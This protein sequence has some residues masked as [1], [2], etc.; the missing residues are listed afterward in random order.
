M[1][2]AHRRLGFIAVL[3]WAWVGPAWAAHLNVLPAPQ[4][5][6]P[7]GRAVEVLIPRAEI[8]AQIDELQLENSATLGGAIS[9]LIDAK[10]NHDRASRAE[11]AIRPLRDALSGFDVEALA[12]ST[13]KAALAQTPWFHATSIAFGRDTTPAGLNAALDAAATDQAAFVTYAYTLSTNGLALS[14]TMTLQL[15]NKA[16]PKGGGPDA[17]FSPGRLAYSQTVTA[18]V[19]LPAPAPSLDANVALWARDGGTAA[20]RALTQAFGKIGVI[21]PRALELTDDD[22]RRLKDADLD[23]VAQWVFRDHPQDQGPTDSV[24]FDGGFVSEATLAPS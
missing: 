18:S 21:L 8:G 2:R 17:R 11:A 20:R 12:L 3:G 15:V 7:A 5:A 9:V 4:R 23:A 16:V 13:T 19:S 14:V 10:V 6:A 22:V 1:A 24:L